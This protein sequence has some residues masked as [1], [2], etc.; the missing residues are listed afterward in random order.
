MTPEQV[1]VEL[2]AELLEWLTNDAHEVDGW[3][4]DLP[5]GELRCHPDLVE[6]LTQCARPVRGTCRVWREGRPVIHHPHGAPIAWASG[7]AEFAVR[8]DQP[9]G[10]L[11]SRLVVAA[12]PQSWLVLDPWAV[13]VSF[14]RT[15]ELLRMHVRRAYELAEANAW[16]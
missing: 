5:I 2:P 16:H 6:R 10:S 11:V 7:T 9:A 15:L 12:L 14:A 8:S 4:P 1:D 3:A 13:D